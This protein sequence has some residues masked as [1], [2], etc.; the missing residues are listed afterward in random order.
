MTIYLEN[1]ATI[2]LSVLQTIIGMM[3]ISTKFG[4]GSSIVCISGFKKSSCSAGRFK[5]HIKVET[6]RNHECEVYIHNIESNW[7]YGTLSIIQPLKTEKLIDDSNKLIKI[8]KKGFQESFWAQRRKRCNTHLP[9]VWIIVKSKQVHH[10][11][12]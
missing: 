4:C 1:L 9:K 8:C 12:G 2:V 7:I 10:Q 11:F 3:K 6:G 5:A